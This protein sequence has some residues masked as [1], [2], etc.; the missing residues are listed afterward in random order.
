MQAYP[1]PI[2]CLHPTEKHEHPL[3]SL[4]PIF[5]Q[6]HRLNRQPLPRSRVA[7]NAIRIALE[8]CNSMGRSFNSE[9]ARGEAF[10]KAMAGFLHDVE[11]RPRLKGDHVTRKTGRI[12]RVGGRCMIFREDKIDKGH[13]GDAYMQVA[14]SYDLACG[15]MEINKITPNAPVSLLCV[16]GEYLYLV[17]FLY[18]DPSSEGPSLVIAGGF[19]DGENTVIE[20]IC[21][22]LFMLKDW[23]NSTGRAAQLAT[24]MFALMSRNCLISRQFLVPDVGNRSLIILV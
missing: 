22:I 2:L 15:Q 16:V 20:S 10:D 19:K 8:L 17:F 18:T 13:S 3:I 23:D 24:R 14:R 21:P 12:Y 9:K 1:R 11:Q 7:V 4:H 5:S 6:F